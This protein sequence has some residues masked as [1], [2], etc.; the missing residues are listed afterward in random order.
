MKKDLWTVT[1]IVEFFE[2]DEAFL[3][4]LEEEDIVCPTCGDDP[5]SKVFPLQELEKVRLAKILVDEMGVN[6]AGVDVILRM[7]RNMTAMRK[8]FD[9]I[10]EA[11]AKDLRESLRET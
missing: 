5:S 1:Q 11:L 10:L 2:I 8:Q 7:R 6:L 4:Q 9:G 3:C